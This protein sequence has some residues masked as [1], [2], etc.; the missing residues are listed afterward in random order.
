MLAACWRRSGALTVERAPPLCW[1]AGRPL[2]AC[3]SS[4]KATPWTAFL[5]GPGWLPLPSPAALC[6]HRGGRGRVGVRPL[7]PP[8]APGASGQQPAA[9]AGWRGGG[10]SSAARGARPLRHLV[11]GA[12]PAVHAVHAVVH[13]ASVA[14]CRWVL[15]LL[16]C[17]QT[18]PTWFQPAP[19]LQLPIHLPPP[20]LTLPHLPCRPAA[21]AMRACLCCCGSTSTCTSA[22]RRHAPARCRCG[23]EG[24]GRG[25][26]VLSTAWPG[27][28]CA[29]L[30][31]GGVQP[32]H[33]A[34]SQALQTASPPSSRRRATCRSPRWVATTSRCPTGPMPRGRC[35]RR[36]ACSVQQGWA[37]Y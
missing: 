20:T 35:T 17:L 13:A 4:G 25:R 6:F 16:L 32:R 28:A 27:F 24:R 7:P 2:P 10:G 19:A 5:T 18:S 22:W 14:V 21:T 29:G 26:F 9:A 34:G 11:S 37:C 3:C 23:R 8:G 30:G 1:G 15:R 33:T 12:E 31:L 36:C